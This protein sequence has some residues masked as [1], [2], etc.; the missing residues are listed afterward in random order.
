M[1]SVPIHKDFTT[2]KPK[3]FGGLTLRTLVCLSAAVGV[4]VAASCLCIFV[5][6]IGVEAASPVIWAAAA[7]AAALGFYTPHGLPAEKFVKIWLAHNW[8]GQLLLYVSPSARTSADEDDD[9]EET[10]DVRKENKYYHRLRRERGIE[11][12]NPGRLP[13]IGR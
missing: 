11:C 2:Y 6:H 3:W 1:L 8:N 5:L 12:W 13:D 4:A 7:P 9:E 10:F